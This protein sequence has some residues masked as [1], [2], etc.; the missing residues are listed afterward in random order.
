MPWLIKEAIER[1]Q[2][3]AS[4]YKLDDCSYVFKCRLV[5]L[6][7]FPVMCWFKLHDILF[8]AKCLKDPVD[9]INTHDYLSFCTETKTR[10]I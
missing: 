5:S 1:V 2:G 8:L 6:N 3:R 10:S 9:N 7:L 4:K